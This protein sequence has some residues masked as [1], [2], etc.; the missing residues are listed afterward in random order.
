MNEKYVPAEV[1]SAAQAHWNATDA[2]R[3]TEDAGKLKFTISKF[4][5]VAG[6]TTQKYGVSPDV[7]YATCATTPSTT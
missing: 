2:Y 4:Y 5:R 6:G 1:E 3:V 7:A